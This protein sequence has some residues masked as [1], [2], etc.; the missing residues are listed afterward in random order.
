MAHASNLSPELIYSS[1]LL[2][3]TALD[4]IGDRPS[5]Q[6]EIL[7][8]VCI[9]E[10]VFEKEVPLSG[11]SFL[12]HRSRPSHLLRYVDSRFKPSMIHRFTLLQLNTVVLRTPKSDP[13]QRS[14]LSHRLLDSMAT[15]IQILNDERLRNHPNVV[16]FLGICWELHGDLKQ[17]TMPIM[18]LETAEAGDLSTY[19]RERP[20]IGARDR[21]RLAIHCIEGLRAVH[22]IGIIHADVKPEN[23]LIFTDK[24]GRPSAKLADFGCS[25]LV[26]DLAI[27]T[28]LESGTPLWQSPNVSNKLDARELRAADGYSLTLVLSLLLIGYHIYSVLEQVVKSGHERKSLQ[29]LK[30]EEGALTKLL[31]SNQI[32]TEKSHGTCFDGDVAGL[33]PLF[34]HTGLSLDEEVAI[35]GT[36]MSRRLLRVMLHR[37]IVVAVTRD[38]LVMDTLDQIEEDVY[39]CPGAWVS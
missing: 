1:H 21:L 15:E 9:E 12:V 13:E 8:N 26:N 14:A 31:S 17:F 28:R 22:D 39:L 37:E 18:V 33:I 27:L 3:K 5:P 29:E 11:G 36:D 23:I 2:L 32:K 7:A 25:L 34:F 30:A 6:V 16:N 19:L 35:A 4:M 24:K 20:E 38:A 10:K